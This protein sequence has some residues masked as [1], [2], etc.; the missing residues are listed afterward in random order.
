MTHLI[1]CHVIIRIRQ[2]IIHVNILNDGCF[3]EVLAERHFL[4]LRSGMPQNDSLYKGCYL[5]D[6]K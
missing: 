3:G 4:A 1:R 2:D 5:L 6:E